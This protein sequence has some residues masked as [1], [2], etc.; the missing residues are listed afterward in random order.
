[1]LVFH[2][3]MQQLNFANF[4]GEKKVHKIFKYHKSWKEKPWDGMMD[5]D[6]C[7]NSHWKWGFET[8]FVD[9]K[10]INLEVWAV[11]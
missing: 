2:V 11:Y 1:V 7:N 5:D 3:L 6:A 10:E 4:F 9:E 8:N